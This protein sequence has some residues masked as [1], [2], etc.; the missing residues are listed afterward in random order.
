ML[1]TPGANADAPYTIRRILVPV[2]FRHD[3][4]QPT[5]IAHPLARYFNAEVTLLH[6]S[7]PRSSLQSRLLP[8]A[9]AAMRRQQR[10]HV[11]PRLA[12]LAANWSQMGIAVTTVVEEGAADATILEQARLGEPTW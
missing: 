4:I 12:E 7:E 3:L 2:D 5:L 9:S 10:Q 8:A 11:V 1:R 6:V